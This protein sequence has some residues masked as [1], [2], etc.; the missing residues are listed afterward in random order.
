VPPSW[1]VVEASLDRVAYQDP[2]RPAFAHVDRIVNDDPLLRGPM[3][4]EV[5]YWGFGYRRL[6]MRT[7]GFK[8]RQAVLWE[9]LYRSEGVLIHARELHVMAGGIRYALNVRSPQATWDR[10]S[11]MLD[12]IQES[13]EVAGG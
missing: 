11:P 7:V 4:D 12:R 3:A 1:E 13:F 6:A 5:T 8:G 9:F 2:K 10:R